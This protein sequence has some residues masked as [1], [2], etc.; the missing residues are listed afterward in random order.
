[1]LTTAHARTCIAQLVEDC[2]KRNYQVPTFEPARSFVPAR[3]PMWLNFGC[4]LLA[5]ILISLLVVGA[6]TIAKSVFG[7]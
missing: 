4:S 3:F 7:W 2:E 6:Y 1:V 5:F